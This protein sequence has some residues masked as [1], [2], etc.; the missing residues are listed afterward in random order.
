M[1]GFIP[2][3]I[4]CFCSLQQNTSRGSGAVL[5]RKSGRLDETDAYQ[6]IRALLKVSLDYLYI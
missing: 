1:H 6:S 4:Q 3:P 5:I 2:F